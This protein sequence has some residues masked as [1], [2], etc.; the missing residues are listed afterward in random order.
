[1]DFCLGWKNFAEWSLHRKNGCDAKKKC[2][3]CSTY[4]H[5]KLQLICLIER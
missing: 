2:G 3:S 4:Q 5:Q 1:M